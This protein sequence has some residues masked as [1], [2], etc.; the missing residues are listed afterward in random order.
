MFLN[1]YVIS[2]FFQEW[3]MGFFAGKS[4]YES[5][6]RLRLSWI[7][8]GMLINIWLVLFLHIKS[9]CNLQAQVVIYD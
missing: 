3:V 9:L 7:E 5:D 8:L 2:S 1:V 4:V 6:G